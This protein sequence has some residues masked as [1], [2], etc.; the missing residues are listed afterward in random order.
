MRGRARAGRASHRAAVVANTPGRGVPAPFLIAQGVV[1]WGGV[2]GRGSWFQELLCV[3]I[4]L[5]Q[6]KD[7]KQKKNPGEVKSA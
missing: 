5:E 3:R 1:G 7:L 2:V 4:T 6:A